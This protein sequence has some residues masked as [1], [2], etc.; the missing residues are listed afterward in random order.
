MNKKSLVIFLGAFAVGG[1]ASYL[2]LD[3]LTKGGEKKPAAAVSK[4]KPSR[5]GWMAPEEAVRALDLPR[6]PGVKN[7][8][9]PKEKAH[10]QA[11]EKE[12]VLKVGVIGPETG[13]DAVYGLS[14]LNGV[15]MGAERFN[16]LGGIGGKNIEVLHFDNK[17]GD[18]LTRNIFTD[19]AR[20][21]V[22]AVFAA[23]TGWSTFA[24]T[25]LANQSKTILI[26]VGS[27]RRIGRSGEYVFQF[28]L[29]DD[30]AIDDMLKFSTNDLGYLDYAMVT[31][32]SYD[33][34]LDISSYFKRAI[35][36]HGGV[37]RVDADTY[38]AMEGKK[39]IPAVIKALKNAVTP[40]QTVIFTGGAEEAAELA[41]AIADAGMKLPLMGGED[42][43][44]SVF[45]EKG[46]HAARGALL[47]ATFAPDEKTPQVAE[48]MD[49]FAKKN[50]GVPDRFTALAYDAF[51]T[52]AF[53]AKDASPLLSSKARDAMLSK[54]DVRGA[55][56]LI[57]W[58]SDGLTIKRPFIYRVEADGEAQKFVLQRPGAQ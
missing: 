11:V 26:S 54:K 43:F 6:Q 8:S 4:A 44:S 31:S 46:G 32:S 9:G 16:A 52:L 12:R 20:Q 40:V 22:I 49:R 56:G 2:L 55:T 37:L 38:D 29:P 57:N 17:E 1:V 58:T 13:E 3:Q 53:A 30:I 7:D 24:P 51:T 10:D 18:L 35:Q 14:V 25:H 39:D 42:L 5:P 27:R 47:Y 33:Y 41:S 50:K 21:G 19:L 45:L 34:S 48:F 28:S 15:M 36:K 23:P